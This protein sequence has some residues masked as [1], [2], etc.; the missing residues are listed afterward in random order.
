MNHDTDIF[1]PTTDGT[2][3]TCS[4][5]RRHFDV[6][7]IGYGPVGATLAG[8]LGRAGLSVGVFD[9]AGAIYPQPR[10]VGFDHD[11][12]RI[13]QRMG[14]ASALAPHI[15]D[16]RDS[17]YYG[18]DGQ[19]IRKVARLP[20]PFP[21]HW[22][23]NYTC[24][25]PGVE[26]VLRATVD[27]MPAVEVHLDSCL[28]ELRDDGQS[29][30]FAV[31]HGQ[32]PTAHCYS[33][34]YLVGCDGAS[35]TVRRSIRAE[36]ASMAYDEPWIVVDLH[37]DPA[38]LDQLPQTNVQY[39]EPRR[40]ST[41]IV[42][43]GNHRR[44]EF[45]VLDGEPREGEL[46]E[47]RLWELL[48][49]WVGPAHA[50]I[51]RAAAYRF[52]AL[53]ARQW[54]AGRVFLAGDSAHQTPPFLGQGMCQGLR[55]AGNL[56]WKL[57]MVIRGSAHARLLETY[58]QERRPHVE[59]TTLLAKEI[60]CLLSE[61]DPVRARARD[62]RLLQEGGGRARTLI[63]QEMI[64]G[65]T[66]GLI[67][68]DAPLAGVTLPQP[69]VRT[70]DGRNCLLDDLHEPD[71]RILASRRADLPELRELAQAAGVALVIVCDGSDAAG[72][73]TSP[74]S[75]SDF[76]GLL[77]AW[78]EAHGVQGVLARPD[79]YVYGG[80][81]DLAGARSLLHMLENTRVRCTP[82]IA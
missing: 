77:P 40:P 45:M 58:T 37:V 55:D 50:R 38:Y 71:F 6:A 3:S 60:G 2:Q 78:F 24:D 79:H 70:A 7:V 73:D 69:R 57:A 20:P 48:R 8:L 31:C 32:S 42:C 53:V 72:D 25:Q 12:M 29:V 36:L 75:V 63:R 27:A 68:A 16:F 76:D 30:C 39:C 82:A 47:P 67:A 62:A 65:I 64:P 59:A 13:F 33:A 9:K 51:W 5:P 14:A 18:A 66:D 4:S 17:C 44:W 52:H 43:P 26:A 61:R 1:R 28:T 74:E 54:G 46:T 49:R 23:P 81:T 41:Y 22:A 34:R 19:M 21:L 11:A 56:A 15:A 35:S 80:F 10:A